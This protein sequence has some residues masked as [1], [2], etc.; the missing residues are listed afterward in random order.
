VSLFKELVDRG[1]SLSIKYSV[2]EP[3][4]LEYPLITVIRWNIEGIRDFITEQ[5][6]HEEAIRQIDDSQK[7][8]PGV[9]DPIEEQDAIEAL[10]DYRAE[11]E[12]S[13]KTQPLSPGVFSFFPTASS[14]QT[15]SLSS[16]SSP[17]P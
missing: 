5:I 9:E 15:T 1:V 7:N 14:S 12:E 16:S 10:L 13:S 11:L 2:L 4:D 3:H 8:F 6:G 17:A